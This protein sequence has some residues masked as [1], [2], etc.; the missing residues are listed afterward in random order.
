[1]SF[2]Q[3]IVIFAAVGCSLNATAQCTQE[4]LDAIADQ[5][6][7]E[8]EA[9]AVQVEEAG[10]LAA[11]EIAQEELD[12]VELMIDMLEVLR[13]VPEDERTKQQWLDSLYNTRF[14]LE[15]EVY[16]G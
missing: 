9:L 16:G 4:E 15:E 3:L 7:T 2:S 1:M 11:Q 13:V 5:I 8:M 12:R 14:S 6:E 10:E